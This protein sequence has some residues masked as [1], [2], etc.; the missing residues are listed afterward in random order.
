L[1]DDQKLS[2]EQRAELRKRLAYPIMSALEKR[3][4]TFFPKAIHGRKMNK[5]L[6]YTYNILERLSR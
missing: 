2:Y 6:S 1:A 3:M 4:E 5:A